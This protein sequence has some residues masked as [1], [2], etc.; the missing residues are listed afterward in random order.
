MQREDWW[1]RQ[2]S[3]YLRM[4]KMFMSPAKVAFFL[5]LHSHFMA[6]VW[7]AL[8][9]EWASSTSLDE[10]FSKYYDAFYWV[11]SIVL[12]GVSVKPPSLSTSSILWVFEML[13]I[14]E[15]IIMIAYAC[16]SLVVNA[17]LHHATNAQVQMKTKD[18]MNYMQEHNCNSDVMMQVIKS[19][20]ETG[21]TRK[22]ASNFRD[23]LLNDLPS[24]LQ[25]SVSRQM[26]AESLT[27]LSLIMHPAQWA[28][29][30]LF[31][32]TQNVREEIYA[33]RVV[34]FKEGDP[35]IDAYMVLK[36]SISI[37][38][39]NNPEK[40]IPPFTQGMW[41][42]EKALVEPGLSRGS[43]GITQTKSTIMVVDGD[44]FRLLLERHGL[45]KRYTNFI[46]SRLWRGL[47][48]R[49]GALGTHFTDTC[50]LV[51]DETGERTTVGKTTSIANI[52]SNVE[53]MRSTHDLQMFLSACDM[54]LYEQF[55]LEIGVSSL[56]DLENMDSDY[57]FERLEGLDVALTEEQKDSLSTKRIHDFEQH[58]TLAMLSHLNQ[59][60]IMVQHLMF[61]SHY[62][63]EAGTEAALMRAELESLIT[64]E[65]IYQNRGQVESAIFLDSEDLTDL[66]E[67]QARVTRSQNLV[68][69][70][71]PGV[72]F[73][74]WVL[75]EL[76]TAVGNGVTVMPVELKKPGTDFVYPDKDFYAGFLD[77]SLLGS[78]AV[79]MLAEHHISMPVAV[80]VIRQILKKIALPYSP[81]RP[82]T[83]R[84]VELQSLLKQCTLGMQG[85]RRQ[86]A[87]NVGQEKDS[88][89]SL[90]LR[91][92]G[93]SGAFA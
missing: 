37:Q 77:G 65:G 50:S 91:K 74:P 30:F 85:M 8:D 6:C 89:E 67:L 55:F 13:L 61:L 75:I 1:Q 7:A 22:L 43:F 17:L 90:L 41:V 64:E 20:R 52:G 40:L 3:G 32:M 88:K 31:D 84:K 14:F 57:L 47:C 9:P 39:R 87:R 68:V 93:F 18:A 62:K 2:M 82:G 49:C 12:I 59:E 78:G 5:M 35:A 66:T 16:D 15:R 72:F 73:R 11:N 70:L 25:K 76:V 28:D 53:T 26:W 71:T 33:S 46:S 4:F 27:S 69:I 10:A 83:I 56:S 81:H 86:D 42:G 45:D 38:T 63:L 44:K 24:E 29:Q 54:A 92:S 58:A 21:H 34:V 36:G 80:D 51:K 79:N 23:I 48:G 19:I 60:R